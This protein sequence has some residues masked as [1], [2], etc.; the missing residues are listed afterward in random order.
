MTTEYRTLLYEKDAETPNILYITLN[1]PEKR[2]AISIGPDEVTGEIQAA[3]SR[4][5]DDDDVKVV[6]FRGRGT[7]FPPVLTCPWS[8]G[9]MV[10]SRE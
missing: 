6:I 7:S 1:R 8:T 3:V 9:P 2:N 5:N 4:A 10:D